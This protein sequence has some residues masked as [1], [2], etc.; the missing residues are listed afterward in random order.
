MTNGDGR[1]VIAHQDPAIGQTFNRWT[2]CGETYRSDNNNNRRCDC[3]CECG[4]TGS[5]MVCDLYSGHS[6]GCG[7]LNI[8]RRLRPYEALHRILKRQAAQR[9]YEVT[10][11]YEEFLEFTREASCHYCFAPITW[12]PYNVIKNKGCRHNIDR[13][14]NSLGYTKENCVV[15]CGRCNWS[16]GCVFSYEEWKQLAAVIRTWKNKGDNLS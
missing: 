5:V 11:T 14:N 3:Q 6:K 16:K 9:D 8:G 7:C 2:V 1:Y 12:E 15:C 4:R 10:L 13:K